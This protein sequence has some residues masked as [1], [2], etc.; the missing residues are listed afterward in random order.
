M[1]VAG[2]MR[3]AVG[4]SPQISLVKSQSLQLQY[5]KQWDRN[6]FAKGNA[7]IINL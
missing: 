2:A 5:P 6:L 7:S 1:D 3:V 4:F